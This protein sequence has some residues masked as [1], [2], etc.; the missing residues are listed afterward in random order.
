MDQREIDR[1]KIKMVMFSNK[2]TKEQK[3]KLI[4]QYAEKY[5][6]ITTQEAVD[7]FNCY[8]DALKE[9][10]KEIKFGQLI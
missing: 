9:G 10:R 7:I 1:K 8:G 2:Y 3:S 4:R 6:A 5:I